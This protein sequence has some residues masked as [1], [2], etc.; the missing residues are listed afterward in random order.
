VPDPPPEP[1]V[2]AALLLERLDVRWGLG[3]T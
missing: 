3:N 1:A 2:V